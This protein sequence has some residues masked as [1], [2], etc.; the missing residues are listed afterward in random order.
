[1]R[2]N[3]LHITR[4]FYLLLIIG[5]WGCNSKGYQ[6]M[7]ARYNGYFYANQYLNETYQSLEDRYAYNFNDVLKVFPEIDSGT[8]NANKA[9][10]DDAFK[11]ASQVIEWY[12]SSDWVDDSYLIIGK[13][14]HLRAQFQFAI[15]TFQYINQTSKDDNARQAALVALM[16][17]YM[18]MGD[19]ERAQDVS[20][21]L[22]LE[23]EITD[24]NNLDYKVLLAE[25]HQRQGNEEGVEE[26]LQEVNELIKNRDQK[27]R[28]NFILGQL[29]Q[30]S[31]N[32]KEATDYYN[33]ALKGNP[34]YELVF[35]AQLNKMSLKDY[36]RS[37]QDQIEKLYKT[38]DKML[39]DGKNL[40]YQDK[41]YYVMGQL[42]QKRSGYDKAIANYRSGTQ[43]EQPNQRQQG[44]TYL[45][46]GEIYFDQFEDYQRSSLYYDSAVAKLPEDEAG[47]DKIVKKQTILKDFV[48]QLNTI[49]LNDSLL[50]LSEMNPVSLDAFLDKHLRAEAAKKKEL[51]KKQNRSNSAS[52][53]IA[54][55][56]TD[57]SGDN[58]WY[59][60]NQAAIGQGQLE[61]QRNWGNRPLEDN[62]RR[63]SKT[64]VAFG[65]DESLLSEE[66][67]E[68]QEEKQPKGESNSE[69]EAEK[70]KLLETIPRTDEAKTAAYQAIQEA[71]FNL[72]RIYRFGLIREDQSAISYETLLS[73]FPN[74]EF[75][76]ESLF[77]LYTLFEV[78]DPPRAAQYKQQIISEFPESL[79]AKT[80]INPNYLQEKEERNIRLQKQ[81]ADAYRMYESG[82]Y[83]GAD[84]MIN[85][86]LASFEDVDF[87]P[88][89]ELL[90]AI[91]KAKTEGLFAY[92]KALEN[93]IAKHPEGPLFDYANNLLTGLKPAKE[94]ILTDR[95]FIF[96]EDFK[97][98]HLVAVTIDTAVN[99][100]KDIKSAIE[101]L[102]KEKFPN[103]RFS[104]GNI[105]FKEKSGIE[106][107]YI[108]SFKTKSASERYRAIMEESLKAVIK[109]EDTNFHNFAISIDNLQFLIDSEEIEE[110]VKF[111]KKFY[112]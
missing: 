2:I 96:S 1:M 44:L 29:A 26:A 56:N 108:N 31:G 97:Q 13:I 38:F 109:Q 6:N 15:E 105:A 42:E 76:L 94:E 10:L 18:D 7:N 21:Y 79:T 83:V 98:L 61:F 71:L 89:V 59:F 48:T 93:F 27:A 23:E 11:K 92:E 65:L 14:R 8:I 85:N 53:I 28:T 16:R 80:L 106:I 54:S 60:Y 20:N 50:A 103:Q 69:F 99:N 30:K 55:T 4:F 101:A 62:W 46:M 17:T 9:K 45:R 68:E 40:E 5:L 87:L 67:R 22:E 41:I 12:K 74:T 49:A 36:S 86:A 84:Q 63:S 102:N 77:A 25:F 104:I 34:P 81:Y 73:R 91:L 100:V 43:V 72:G 57:T 111:H 37:S 24:A 75:K 33:L 3:N 82:N 112:K 47:Y 90:S 39:R 32:N 58:T 95:G 88:T 78:K 64:S 107:M 66:E 70:E 51:E 35:H 52:N 19:V 110:Y